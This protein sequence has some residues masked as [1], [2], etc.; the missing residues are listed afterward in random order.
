M[1]ESKRPRAPQPAAD[2][3]VEEI[4]PTDAVASVTDA[5]AAPAAVAIAAPV[6]GLAD[7]DK[8]ELISHEVSLINYLSPEV[9]EWKSVAVSMDFEV[10][11][12][13][14]ER[15]IQFKQSQA[16]TKVSAGV[17]WGFMGWF[18]LDSQYSQTRV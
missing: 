17:S 2:D 5:L 8:T 3:V 10:G 1:A 4:R 9:H 13:D 11:A 7:A 12:M 16:S 6:D 14:S 15:G 18:D